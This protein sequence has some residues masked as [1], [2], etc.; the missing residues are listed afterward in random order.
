MPEIFHNMVRSKL[1]SIFTVLSFFLASSAVAETGADAQS[2]IITDN[3]ALIAVGSDDGMQGSL[4]SGIDGSEYLGT[5][6]MFKV[7][8]GNRTPEHIAFV[9]K[10]NGNGYVIENRI[11]VTCSKKT[12]CTLPDY[13]HAER[14]GK[15][16]YEIIVNDYENWKLYMEE[17]KSIDGV[18]KF[19]PSLFFGS[20]L[21]LK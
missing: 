9:K 8:S 19:S 1:K 18:E 17:L 15:R 14:L 20:R 12:S 13:F 10:A 7:V 11:I 4:S 21:V 5:V 6:G 16:R 3:F 2:L